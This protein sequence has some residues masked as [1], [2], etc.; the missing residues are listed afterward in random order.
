MHLDET[1]LQTKTVKEIVKVLKKITRSMNTSLNTT[2]QIHH[3]IEE[4]D[5][6][7]INQKLT[8][9]NMIAR[10]GWRI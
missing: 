2:Q 5:R 10:R 4:H 7:V 3:I 8:R 9:K 1:I 6:A